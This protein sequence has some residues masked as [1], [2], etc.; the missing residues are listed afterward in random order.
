M[1]YTMFLYSISI[2][3]GSSKNSAKLCAHARP[4]HEYGSGQCVAAEAPHQRKSLSSY[5]NFLRLL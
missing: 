3:Y 4:D 5:F 1:T 2:Q